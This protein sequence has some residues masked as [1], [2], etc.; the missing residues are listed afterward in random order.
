MQL[1]GKLDSPYVRRVAIAL[2]VLDL[3]FER[4]DVSVFRDYDAFAK[5]NPVVKAPTLFED[6]GTM[7]LDSTL[8]LDYLDQKVDPARRLMPQDIATRLRALQVIGLALA[9][10]E[11]V[12]QIVYERN[13]RP[14]ERQHEPW[15]DRVT[16]QMHAAFHALDTQLGT[17]IGNRD[18]HDAWL[19]GDRLMLPDI[20]VA[21]TWFFTHDLLPGAID[22]ADY[23]SIAAFAARAETLPAFAKCVP[24]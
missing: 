14:A 6:D 4:R 9:A 20:T 21:V 1:I 7:L 22:P 5:I 10:T 12:M 13:L 16:T 23:P 17:L 8:I 11:K 2:A 3:P 18:A 24:A 15:I 19:L